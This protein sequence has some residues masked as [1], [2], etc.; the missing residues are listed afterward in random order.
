MNHMYIMTY[1]PIDA[2]PVGLATSVLRR[3]KAFARHG[4]HNT[5]LIN[6]FYLHFEQSIE[7]L[8]RTEAILPE[9][10]VRYLY[11]E[12]AGDVTEDERPDVDPLSHSDD[13]DYK[14]D[15]NGEPVIRAYQN[16]VYKRFI[17]MKNGK[18]YFIDQLSETGQR[19]SRDWYDP[20]GYLRKVDI[21]DDNNQCVLIEY[22]GRNG[23]HFLNLQYH[24]NG[25][26]QQS[27]EL[28]IETGVSLHFD[29]HDALLYYWL[30]SSLLN[31]NRD[32]VLISEYGFSKD[33]L[34]SLKTQYERFK[35]IYTL[36]NN[37]FAKPYRYGSGI[38]PEL[39]PFFENIRD[40]DAVVVLT[41]SQKHDIEKQYFPI[42]N[43]YAI[44]HPAA[45]YEAP[46]VNRDSN[47]VVLLGRLEDH[48]GQIDA[49]NAFSSVV[50]SVPDAK[51]EI[52]GRGSTAKAIQ[53]TIDDAGLRR[54]VQIVGFSK[55]SRE[56]YASASVALFP[57]SYE[58]F[59]LSLQESM[60]AGCVPIAYDFK[61][62]AREMIYDRV[63]GFVVDIKN[64]DDLADTVV[65]LLLNPELCEKM[66]LEAELVSDRFTEKSVVDVWLG[67]ADKLCGTGMKEG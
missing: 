36:H 33:V 42:D 58:G 53:K 23:N 59:S 54:N 44:P 50:K 5:I 46:P 65:M 9:T 38:K 57:S 30:E 49:V 56:V 62:G 41:D 19:F 24:G 7:F 28:F 67:L 20:K 3:S 43:V 55:G 11:N 18:V 4:V 1:G 6:T 63:N 27:A 45:L 2:H 39:S 14:Q 34:Q 21:M 37:H 64:V 17:W 48:K 31:K 35:V 22:Y 51:L 13:W 66:S 61:Y 47:K 26:R 32:V 8:R 15:P 60:V 16:G 25:K 52:Y 12:L 29:S 40:Y 10:Y